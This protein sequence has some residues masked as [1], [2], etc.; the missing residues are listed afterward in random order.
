MRDDTP[1]SLRSLQRTAFRG[2]YLANV[3]RQLDNVWL[4]DERASFVEWMALAIPPI[5]GLN[6]AGRLALEVD[7]SIFVPERMVS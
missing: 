7:A 1:E 6:D 2:Q 5:P 4:D 3:L